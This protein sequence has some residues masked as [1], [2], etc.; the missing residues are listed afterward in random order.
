MKLYDKEY[1]IEQ[2]YR[3]QKLALYGLLGLIFSA[4][5][6]LQL[7]R[8]QVITDFNYNLHEFLY[9]QFTIALFVV[10]LLFIVYIYCLLTYLL[11]RGKRKP[12]FKS[13]FQVVCVLAS[14]IVI[15]LI[16]AYQFQEV[17]TGGVYMV[18]KKL[19]EEKKY[20]LVLDNKKVSV[21]YNDFENVEENQPYLI[22]LFGIS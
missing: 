12:S 14:L 2:L 13:S 4:F 1:E 16:T 3:R 20:Y 11:K 22:T 6:G 7:G 17:S 9:A 8:I 19:Q 10:P 15:G 5:I 18:E 21:S